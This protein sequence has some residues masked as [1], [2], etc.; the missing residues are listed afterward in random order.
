MD[1]KYYKDHKGLVTVILPT[2]ALGDPWRTL[3]CSGLKLHEL[4]FET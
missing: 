3:E 1:E 2:P 4:G